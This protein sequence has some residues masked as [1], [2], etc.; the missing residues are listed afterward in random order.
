MTQPNGHAGRSKRIYRF[1]KWRE[2]FARREFFLVRG[3]DYFC[4]DYSI[5]Q[6]IRSAASRLGVKVRIRPTP[7]G[8]TITV[9][10]PLPTRNQDG[11]RIP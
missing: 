9:A 7:T 5:H 4:A 11:E 8:F 10:N 6:Q 1:Y 3:Q 2:W